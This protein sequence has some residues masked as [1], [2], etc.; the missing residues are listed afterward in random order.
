MKPGLSRLDGNC[1]SVSAAAV[2]LLLMLSLYKAQ[3]D[4]KS[5]TS[6]PQSPQGPRQQ[7][8]ETAHAHGP[9]LY[10]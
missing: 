8:R 7:A 3:A 9:F 1:S 6:K 10:F 4:P 2:H 5:E